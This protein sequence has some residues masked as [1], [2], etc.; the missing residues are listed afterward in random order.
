MKTT[1]GR[2][3][4]LAAAACVAVG[5]ARGELP[6]AQLAT[7]PNAAQNEHEPFAGELPANSDALRF[8]NFNADEQAKPDQGYGHFQGRFIL[9]G[10]PKPAKLAIGQDAA[11]CGKFGLVDESIKTSADGGLANVVVFVLPDKND[12]PPEPHPSYA[13]TAAAEVVL[14]NRNCQF[15]PRVLLVRTS[16]KFK[17]TN[18]DSISHNTKIEYDPDPINPNILPGQSIKHAFP[19]EQR[20]PVSVSCSSHSWMQAKL[21]VRDSPYMAVTDDEGNFQIENL[22]V[23]KWTFQFWHEALGYIRLVNVGGRD[24]DWARGRYEVSIDSEG[25][26]RLGDVT[27]KMADFPQ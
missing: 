18:S 9:E 26:S 8:V 1:T 19:E 21:V 3:C 4:L 25:V 20:L 11:F 13:K 10:A 16:Q 22:P 24:A 15:Q 27:L 12:G 7:S 17:A 23:G 5:C 2:N 6:V 14:D